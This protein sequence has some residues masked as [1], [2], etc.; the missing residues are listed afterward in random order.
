M[1]VRCELIGESSYRD[2]KEILKN[3]FKDRIEK[4]V[5]TPKHLISFINSTNIDYIWFNVLYIF[6]L[7]YGLTFL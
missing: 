7:S 5:Y 4:E 6:Y 3:S 1:W 2:K